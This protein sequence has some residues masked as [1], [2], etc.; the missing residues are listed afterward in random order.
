MDLVNFRIE[1]CIFHE[2]VPPD[3]NKDMTTTILATNCFSITQIIEDEIIKRIMAVMGRNT[4]DS[5]EFELDP[6][7]QQDTLGIV[8]SLYES[9]DANYT[10]ST[11]E[12]AER[13][14]QVQGK[15]TKKLTGPLIILSGLVGEHN[16]RYTCIIKADFTTGLKED[17]ENEIKKIEKIFLTPE[18]DFY[19]VALILEKDP[20]IQKRNS[21]T[22]YQFFV[23]DRNVTIQSEK[24]AK[25]FFKDFLG[26]K[27]PNSN[28]LK[29]KNFFNESLSF[30][31]QRDELKSD[32]KVSLTTHLYSYLTKATQNTVNSHSFADSYITNTELKSDY[33]QVME[34]MALKSFGKDLKMLEGKL[35][36]RRF[37]FTNGYDLSIDHTFMKKNIKIKTN[38]E[39]EETTFVIQG[40]IKKD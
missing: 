4:D 24:I 28:A 36:K 35:K 7:S 21:S 31:N 1:K 3:T 23:Y 32:D 10:K 30:I 8:N 11:G 39:K 38:E 29:T 20:T 12:I 18:K 14:A 19:K 2:I 40:L 13:L 26:L 9:D 5:I 27:L 37:T 6:D 34:S 33:K 22:N 25:Y 16:H 17:A 15:S